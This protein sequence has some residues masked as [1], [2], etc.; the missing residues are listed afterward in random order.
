MNRS[1]KKIKSPV[2]HNKIVDSVSA[3]ELLQALHT[4]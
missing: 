4:L 3:T 2:K 1:I